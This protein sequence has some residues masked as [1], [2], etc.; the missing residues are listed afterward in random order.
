MTDGIL[1][2]TVGLRHT[3]VVGRSSVD[4]RLRL[5]FGIPQS[6]VDCRQTIVYRLVRCIDI[7]R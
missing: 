7:Y 1:L 4:G 6:P 5:A 2:S 3:V